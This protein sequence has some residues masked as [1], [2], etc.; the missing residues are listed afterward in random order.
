VYGYPPTKPDKPWDPDDAAY[1]K[2]RINTV[3]QSSIQGYY[4]G[5]ITGSIGLSRLIKKKNVFEASVFYEKSL[6][7]VGQQGLKMD[8]IGLR[9][10]YLFKVK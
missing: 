6:G 7:T 1:K 10:A 9:T 3:E 8:Q 4:G 2:P 5:S